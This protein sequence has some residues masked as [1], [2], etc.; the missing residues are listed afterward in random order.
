MSPASDCLSD[1]HIILFYVLP[2]IVQIGTKIW[3]FFVVVVGAGGEGLGVHPA[4]EYWAGS[5]YLVVAC[6]K[7]KEKNKT[8]Q[9]PRG[10]VTLAS[11]RRS[12][13]P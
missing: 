12:T 7:K 10:T 8:K 3:L 1:R 11:R 2:S 6:S 9:K 5:R 13:C 4:L